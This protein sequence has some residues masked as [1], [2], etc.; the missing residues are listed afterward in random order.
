TGETMRH[1]TG[2][3]LL[4]VIFACG[5]A[6]QPGS[7][8]S[9]GGPQGPSIPPTTQGSS[10]K[11]K[12]DLSYQHPTLGLM[13]IGH[14]ST[15]TVAYGTTVASMGFQLYLGDGDGDP[16]SVVTT[17]PTPGNT[18]INL[19]EWTSAKALVPYTLT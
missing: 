9:S 2:M 11:P 17:M 8:G 19:A 10:Y 15:V 13:Q 16:V 6:A 4:G 5:L 12:I 1:M 7:T 18:G 3:L 14:K